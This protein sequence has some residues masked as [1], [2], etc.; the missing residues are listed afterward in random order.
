MSLKEKQSG[1][2]Y[3]YFCYIAMETFFSKSI[4]DSFDNDARKIDLGV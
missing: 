2:R 1:M 4:Y 3:L